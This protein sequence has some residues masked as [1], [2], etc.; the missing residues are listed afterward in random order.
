[1][2]FPRI[3]TSAFC[4]LTP[5]FAFGRVTSV[6]VTSRADLGPHYEK[7]AGIVHFAVDPRNPHNTV[8]VDLDKAPR[9]AAG[10]VEFSADFY[11]VRPKVNGNGTLFL[12]IANRGGRIN[13]KS[14]ADLRDPFLLQRGYTMAYVGWQFD[15]RPDPNRVR[16]NAPVAP[17]ITGRV[18]ADWVVETKAD[19]HTVSHVIGGAIGGTGYPVADINARDSVLTER[20]APTA[21]RRTIPRSQ[22]RF[23]DP[24][25]VH[26][27]GGFVPGK[28]YEVIYTAKD[29]AIVG[30]GLAAVRD[31]VSWAKYDPQSII[32]SKRAYGF[33]ISQSGRF[34][35]HF[36]YQGFN[37]DEQGRQVFDA[38]NAHV[39]GS[40]R[41]SFNGRFQQPS[42]D[43]EPL[44]PLFYPNDLFPFADLPMKDPLSG[45]TEGLLDKAVAE[46][47]VPKIFY[48]NTSYEYW[49]RGE[50]LCHTTPDATA[51]A[52]IPPT[53]RIYFIAGVAHVPGPYPPKKENTQNLVNPINYW[54]PLHA[55][56]D[57]L[58][59]WVR[60]GT[61]PP[62]SNYPHISDGTLVPASH[63]V[64]KFQV[65]P[66]EPYKMILG[67][68]PPKVVGAYP[69]LVPQV[70]VDGNEISGIRQ[71]RVAVP[72]ATYTGWNLRDPSIGF[73]ETRMNFLGS[74]IPFTSD[75]YR[76]K[77]DYLGRYTAATLKLIDDRFLAPE[78]VLPMLR[79]G[80]EE[81]QRRE[82]AAR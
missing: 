12:E 78:D 62:P 31:F 77:S 35:R 65:T 72:L 46:K 5:A 15:V 66:Y 53:S 2:R 50:S 81:W 28:I 10:E 8:I 70:G 29:P 1:M 16:L 79:I 54:P 43:S 55:L 30:C 9:N 34:L 82:E 60:N 11:V 38:I 80:L 69:A 36:V 39:A 24:T 20:D 19:E 41:G 7:I 51:D 13:P 21:Q 63:L 33:G 52:P 32:A 71:A 14:E 6:D 27:D 37:A 64:V 75:P 47:V 76:D 44:S 23:T 74:Y 67:D 61:E 26:L 68:E 73:P 56:W 42:R 17:G 45:R 59:A 18:R 40:G 49:S 57:A 4:L 3:I 22:W 25:T 58:D 48:T